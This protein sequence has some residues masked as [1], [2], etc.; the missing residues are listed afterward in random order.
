MGVQAQRAVAEPETTGQARSLKT[1][2]TGRRIV[3]LRAP[4]NGCSRRHFNNMSAP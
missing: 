3:G 1:P 4:F 2:L